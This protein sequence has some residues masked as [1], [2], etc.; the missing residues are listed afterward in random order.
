MGVSS[1]SERENYKKQIDMYYEIVKSIFSSIYREQDP[2]KTPIQ[3][4]NTIRALLAQH[5]MHL[6]DIS[7]FYKKFQLL[8]EQIEQG[9]ARSAKHG[10]L[11]LQNEETW[12]FYSR[13]KTIYPFDGKIY[14]S[15]AM[16][17]QKDE[18]TLLGVYNLMRS[19]ACEIPHEASKEQLIDYFEDIRMKY[20]KLN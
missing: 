8:I 5:L 20:I 12:N 15:F 18:D 7:K 11:N 3:Y 19:L 2:L 1:V 17:Y 14:N 13:A 16:L 4:E 9:A 6:G 10:Q